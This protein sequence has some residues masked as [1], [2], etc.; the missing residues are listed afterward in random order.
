MQA[1]VNFRKASPNIPVTPAALPGRPILVVMTTHPLTLETFFFRQVSYFTSQGFDV[2]L[3][4]A[5]GAGFRGGSVSAM[6]HAVPMTRSITPFADAVALYRIWRL[7]RRLR[8]AIVHTHTPKAGLLGMIAAWLAGIKVRIYTINGLPLMTRRGWQHLMLRYTE[9]ISCMMSTSTLCVSHSLR[10]FAVKNGLCPAG[11]IS[12]LGAGSSHGVNLNDFNPSRRTP[13][14]RLAARRRYGIPDDALVLS[15]VGRLVGDKGLRELADA[16]QQI[17]NNFQNLHLLVAG[18]EEQQDPL[19][20]SVLQ[21]FRADPRV[22]MLGPVFD[23]MPSIYAA[24]DACVLPTYREGLSNVALECGAMG[25]PIV[26]TRTEGCIDVVQDGATGLL[27]PV[28]NAR[29]LASA[30]QRLL[31]SEELRDRL[32]QKAREVV[33]SQFAEDQVSELL[34]REYCRLL[35]SAGFS[36]IGTRERHDSNHQ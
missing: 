9:K 19:P 29:A 25:L 14:R 21:V 1:G 2:H 33:S 10:E 6:F 16:W 8:P 22:H 26:A 24:T 13:E 7:F 3:I 34:V 18:M 28:Q 32:G 4:S 20:T 5:P 35:V 31:S 36:A 23:D 12:T 30:L 11:K 15:Y 27:V 17:K